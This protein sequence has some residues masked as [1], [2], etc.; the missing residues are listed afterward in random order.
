MYEDFNEISTC[1]ISSIIFD[2]NLCIVFDLV[3]I[4]ENNITW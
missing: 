2:L 3:L 4:G 1:F